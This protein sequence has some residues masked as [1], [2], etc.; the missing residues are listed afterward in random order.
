VPFDGIF[1]RGTHDLVR[2]PLVRLTAGVTR[3]LVSDFTADVLVRGDLSLMVLRPSTGTLTDFATSRL[4]TALAE[5]VLALLPNAV[6]L[7][8]GELLLPQVDIALA[9]GRPTLGGVTRRRPSAAGRHGVT[10]LRLRVQGFTKP[11]KHLG[12]LP[13]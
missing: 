2:L 11:A 5:T 4:E 8:A 6:A 13:G 12:P 10:H 7:I 1:E 9:L 3:H